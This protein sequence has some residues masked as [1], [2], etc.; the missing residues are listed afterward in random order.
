MAGRKAALQ[1][2]IAPGARV[3][4]PAGEKRIEALRTA[5]LVLT[6]DRGPQPVRWVGVLSPWR[7]ASVRISRQA[8]ELGTPC[9]TLDVLPE[10]RILLTGTDVRCG[11]GEDTILV[12][13]KHLL[14]LPGVDETRIQ[15]AFGLVL[16]QPEIV[17][18]DGAPV[19]T[20][21]HV[22]QED[23]LSLDPRLKPWLLGAHPRPEPSFEALRP[24]LEKRMSAA[25][26]RRNI[27]PLCSSRLGRGGWMH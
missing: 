1:G 27:M 16:E 7:G 10:Q 14:G 22:P 3:L 6:L 15:C 11:F 25:Q 24:L 21:R 4:G 23:S 8:L 26:P 19:S 2:G 9:R 18:V 12:P 5:D 13:A 17:I 20:L